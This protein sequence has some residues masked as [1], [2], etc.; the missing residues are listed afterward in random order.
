[1]LEAIRVQGY[2]AS[3]EANLI[4]ASG[5]SAPVFGP[6]GAVVAAICIAA[7]TARFQAV[8]AS[9]KREIIAVARS[10]SDKLSDS[11]AGNLSEPP[12]RSSVRGKVAAASC[13]GR[14]RR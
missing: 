10:L 14:K 1:M 2:A 6:N 3:Y 11:G 5:Y 4:G 8:R 13:T 12:P 7:P 9:L